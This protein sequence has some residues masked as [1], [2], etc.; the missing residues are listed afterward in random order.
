VNTRELDTILRQTLDDHRLSRTERKALQQFLGDDRANSGV[1]AQVRARAFDIA[2]EYA[3]TDPEATVR[4]LEG[5]VKATVPSGAGAKATAA[6]AYFSPG[7][8]CRNRIEGLLKA[9]RRTL[10][11]CVFTITDDAL[12]DAV[13]SAHKRGVAVRVISDNDKAH[14]TGSDIR[15]FRGAGVPLV[16]DLTDN[17]MHHKFGIFDGRHLMTGSYNWTRS[18]FRYNH[19]NIVVVDDERLIKKFSR[20]FDSLWDSFGGA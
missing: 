18:A 3:G 15:K 13:I 11:L 4:W 6:E 14:D 16:V 10:D 2:I 19:E 9:A 7:Q 8:G 5:I 17:H 20:T 12:T 1:M